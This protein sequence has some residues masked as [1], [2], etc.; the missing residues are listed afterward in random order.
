[1]SCGPTRWSAGGEQ[2]AAGG[3]MDGI[4]AKYI[5][6]WQTRLKLILNPTA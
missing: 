1:M 5:I 4:T 2:E 6:G 3:Y